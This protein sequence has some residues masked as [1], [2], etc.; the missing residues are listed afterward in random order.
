MS[1]KTTA[2]DVGAVRELV[3][4][5]QRVFA[6]SCYQWSCTGKQK[7]F[8][9]SIEVCNAV[10]GIWHMLQGQQLL[11]SCD[12]LS[13]PVGM[14]CCSILPRHIVFIPASNT[15]HLGQHAWIE[16]QFLLGWS[17]TPATDIDHC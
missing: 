1:C 8:G 7:Q 2:A 5:K 10:V 14:A 11:A 4:M 3:G 9:M 12:M 6:V 13:Q 15:K 16:Q 17:N